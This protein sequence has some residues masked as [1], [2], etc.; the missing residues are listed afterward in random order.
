MLKISLEIGSNF[1]Y[2]IEFK[3]FKKW[4]F[5][6]FVQ[7]ILTL[8]LSKQGILSLYQFIPRLFKPFLPIICCASDGDYDR[9]AFFL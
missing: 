1:R 9:V 8:L 4:L 3:D 6:V 5:E 7:P 2:Y